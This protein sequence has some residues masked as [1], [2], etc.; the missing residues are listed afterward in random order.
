MIFNKTKHTSLTNYFIDELGLEVAMTE[1]QIADE[2]GITHQRVHQLLQSAMK[3]VKHNIEDLY[4]EYERETN[5]PAM[6]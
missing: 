5:T 6:S 3:K 1:Q 2:L 4:S